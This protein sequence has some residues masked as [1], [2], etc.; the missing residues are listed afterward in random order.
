MMHELAYLTDEQAARLADVRI[1]DYSLFAPMNIG[2][3]W[4]ITR[5]EVKACDIE[6][7]KTLPIMEVEVEA[8]PIDRDKEMEQNRTDGT[9]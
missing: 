8:E 9:N 1:D 6:W 7:V 3:K 4:F 2:G 5:E